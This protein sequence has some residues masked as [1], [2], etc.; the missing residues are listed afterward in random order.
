MSPESASSSEEIVL[1]RVPCRD[2]QQ[3]I[4]QAIEILKRPQ[5]LK[6]AAPRPSAQT[7]QLDKGRYP[8]KIEAS[9]EQ[10]AT[11]N[12]QRDHFHHDWNYTIRPNRRS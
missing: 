11:I 3:R 7:S 5:R 12:M 4:W 2:A 1:V 9:D 8:T 10:L 6:T